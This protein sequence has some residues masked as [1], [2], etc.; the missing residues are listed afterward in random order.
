MVLQAWP[1]GHGRMV[2]VELALDGFAETTPKTHRERH[3]KPGA[4]AAPPP[5]PSSHAVA[6]SHDLDAGRRLHTRWWAQTVFG[7]PFDAC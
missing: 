1:Y 3:V 4:A 5:L 6:P 7:A 2:V